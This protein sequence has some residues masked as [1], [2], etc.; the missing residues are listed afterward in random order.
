MKTTQ[1][2]RQLR[3]ITPHIVIQTIWE[4]DTDLV[5]IRTDTDGMDDAD[6]THWQAWIAEVRASA[7]YMDQDISG[8]AF[9]CGIWERADDLPE[10]SNPTV[11][12]YEIDLTIEALYDLAAQLND[13]CNYLHSINDLIN[14]LKSLP[15]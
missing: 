10:E 7:T 11:S 2:Q 9:L 8:S 14:H 3:T 12:S 4:H 15:Q 1:L 6:P 13:D 5:D